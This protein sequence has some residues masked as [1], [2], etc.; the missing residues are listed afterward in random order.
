MEKPFLALIGYETFMYSYI[1]I[2]SC[3]GVAVDTKVP[4]M[5]LTY[6]IKHAQYFALTNN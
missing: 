4:L 3:D 6:L 2:G 5:P 1:G